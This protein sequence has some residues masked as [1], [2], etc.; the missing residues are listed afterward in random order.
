M[1]IVDK[2][3]K[4]PLNPKLLEEITKTNNENLE[5]LIADANHPV[6]FKLGED[7]LYLV[8]PQILL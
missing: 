8:V 4:P 6:L 2:N 7:F 3:L 1:F 5:I